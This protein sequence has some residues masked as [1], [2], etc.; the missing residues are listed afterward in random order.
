MRAALNAF[1]HFLATCQWLK[2]G[3]GCVWLLV[4]QFAM[5]AF[6]P[7]RKLKGSAAGLTGLL[8]FFLCFP[9]SEVTYRCV[10][11]WEEKEW[12][13]ISCLSAFSFLLSLREEADFTLSGIKLCCTFEPSKSICFAEEDAKGK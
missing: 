13:L 3:Q 11:G 10:D 6:Q 9:G 2:S 8:L 5:R 7:H 12:H 1:W 4:S